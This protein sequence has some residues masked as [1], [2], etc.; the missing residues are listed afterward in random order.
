[1]GKVL[2]EDVEYNLGRYF[3]FWHTASIH[4]SSQF[5]SL[6]KV[7]YKNIS[8]HLPIFIEVILPC[9]VFFKQIN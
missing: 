1:M 8:I 9:L 4:S 5:Q 6:Q 2:L 3:V 7:L